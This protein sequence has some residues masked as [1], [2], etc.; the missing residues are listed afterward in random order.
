M[1]VALG[2]QSEW[3]IMGLPSLPPATPTIIVHSNSRH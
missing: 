2:L 1:F 3:F